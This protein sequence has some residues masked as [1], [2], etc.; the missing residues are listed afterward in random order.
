[1]CAPALRYV[2]V[3]RSAAL[4]DAQRALLPLEPPDEA[5][6]P[7]VRRHHDDT[8]V[9]AERAGPVVASLAELPAVEARAAVVVANELLDNIPFGIA[10]WDGAQWSEVR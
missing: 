2:L 10:Q 9:P 5:L 6:G 4:R 1:E 7:F 8:P 3:E